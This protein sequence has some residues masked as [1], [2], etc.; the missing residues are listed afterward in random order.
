V[1]GL[2]PI[3]T[4]AAAFVGTHFI[5]ALVGAALPDRK[6]EALQPDTWPDWERKT[7]S[8]PFAA[9]VSGTARLGGFSMHAL[10]GSVVL[11][12]ARRDLGAHSARRLAGGHLALAVAEV[13]RH[14]PRSAFCPLGSETTCRGSR[15]RREF[16]LCPKNG[17]L[18]AI[19][20]TS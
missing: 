19:F 18:R 15:Q 11:C 12:M 17:F 14:T 3:A 9:I 6:K 1:E 8:W 20:S 10:V 4:A 13:L 7:S 2:G 5:L 16:T